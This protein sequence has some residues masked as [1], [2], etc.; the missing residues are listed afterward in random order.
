MQQV[1]R[2]FLAIFRWKCKDRRYKINKTCVTSWSV[3]GGK[4]VKVEDC[5]DWERSA[6]CQWD[7]TYTVLPTDLECVLRYCDNA[8]NPPLESNLNYTWDGN[9]GPLLNLHEWYP[10][11]NGWA[12]L[13]DTD[14]QSTKGVN[15]KC[16]SNGEYEYPSPW[17][18]CYSTVSCPDPGNSAEVNRTLTYGNLLDGDLFDYRANL[19]YVCSDPRKYIKV[20]GSTDK[21]KAD[22]NN[23]C[24]WRKTF[25][26]DGTALEC[27]MHHCTYPYKEPGAHTKPPDDH[28]IVLVEPTGTT[29]DSWHVSFG[30]NITYKCEGNRYIENDQIDPTVTEYKVQ[31]DTTGTYKVPQLW[32]NCTETVKCGQPPAKPSN[33]SI[34]GVFGYEGSIEWLS[35]AA[36]LQDTYDTK[37]KYRCVNGSQFKVD[38]KHQK[39]LQNKCQWNKSWKWPT[40]PPCEVTHCTY[41]A[42]HNPPPAENNL[43]LVVP[44]AWTG[45]PEK[46]EVDIDATITYKCE[47]DTFFENDE[48]DPT[49]TELKV[50]CLST[51]EYESPPVLNEAWPNCTET[52]RCGQPPK[53]PTNGFVNGVPGFDGE[54]Q[55]LSP[56]NNLEDTY[57]TSVEYKCAKG[58]QF[59]V[60]GQHSRTIR[61]RC[62]WNKAWAP[63]P[64]LPPCV[65]THCTHPADHNPPPPENHIALLV[66]TG[67][68][69][70]TWEVSF[71][72]HITYRCEGQRYF[73]NQE[74]D[75]TVT[76]LNVTCLTT[77]E[78]ESPV[79]LSTPWP[80]C[81]ETVN[82]G[83]PPEKPTNG[84]INGQDGFDGS[85]TWISPANEL[86]DTYDTW[87]E[88]K[89]ADGSQFDTDSTPEGLAISLRTRCQWNK[90]WAPY[91]SLPPCVVTHCVQP[92]VIPEDSFLEEI[93]SDWTEVGAKK[94]YRCQGMKADG[95]HTR[96][97]ESDRTKSSF[98]MLCLPDGSYKFVDKRDNWPTCLEG[99]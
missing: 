97:W 76:M 53:K 99:D 54:I 80:N 52:V 32:P 20:T 47:G 14:W 62:Q 11:K 16:N 57:N 40:L 63:H 78:Y 64:S 77:G 83:Q 48:V 34:N 3:V 22:L 81:T 87:V 65:V 94:E 88:Y 50:K 67:W 70:E 75:P 51:G 12:L 23:P 93:T 95:T 17:P 60:N 28:N 8:T 41:P 96:F 2:Y 89:C 6:S 19:K 4:V 13:T 49:V 21:I 58:S 86:Q 82:C 56:A 91:S 36:D 98:E 9:L 25:P 85:I 45:T 5:D 18:T 79:V 44:S 66:P 68:T 26:I 31:C 72:D 90:E 84:I 61:N 92:F 24:H 46:W 39:T 10:C 59:E 43:V 42:D 27:Q 30:K 1:V 29:I 74:I 69:P 38:N 37:V 55:W 15:V 33:L 71:G 7:E 73:E 35:P